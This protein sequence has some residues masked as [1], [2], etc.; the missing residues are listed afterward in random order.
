MHIYAFGSVCRG[1]IDLGS[2]V[3][4]L[5]VA[6]GQLEHVNPSDYSIYSYERI[7]ELWEQGNPFAW[8]LHL[9]S[10][11]VFSQDGSNFLHEL[12]KPNL[13]DSGKA[14]CLK[15]Y[16][17]FN[18]ARESICESSM[19]LVFDLSTI[20][21]SIRNFAT[22]YSLGYSDQPD[23]SRRSSINLGRSS[24]DIDKEAFSILESAR[25]LCTRGVGEN[26]TQSQIDIAIEVI[27]Q[28][29]TWMKSLISRIK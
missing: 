26:L 2:D 6:K 12:G 14:D 11:L 3:D 29:E 18:S 24:L 20:F 28:I 17:I 10:K 13:Y 5:M 23:F 19:S 4:M 7:Q 27:P 9:E 22:C 1:D 15:F 16:D 21:L 25:I 8:H